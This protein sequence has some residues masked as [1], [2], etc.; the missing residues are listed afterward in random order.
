ML[1]HKIQRNG[2]NKNV[3][4]SLITF[5]PAYL[6]NKNYS[7]LDKAESLIHELTAHIKNASAGH[8]GYGINE[9]DN[10]GIFSRPRSLTPGGLAEKIVKYLTAF[11]KKT[12]TTA[13]EKG[14]NQPANDGPKDKLDGN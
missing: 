4:V 8:A 3:K 6:K 5:N 13:I 14:A 12:G 2:G 10:L 1:A 7:I 11:D 9:N